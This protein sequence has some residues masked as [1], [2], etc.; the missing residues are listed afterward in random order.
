[1][2]AQVL[3]SESSEAISHQSYAEQATGTG[4][5]ALPWIK[6]TTGFVLITLI[7]YALSFL[8]NDKLDWA[9]LQYVNPDRPV[10]FVDGLMILV[11]DYSMAF[12]GLVLLTLQITCQVLGHNLFSKEG[13]R[14]ALGITGG[15]F[16][17][18]I[19]SGYIWA[20]Y[21]HRLIFIPLALSLLG[22]Y[23]FLGQKIGHYDNKKIR[24]VSRL[25]GITLLSVLLTELAVGKI[26]KP[27]VLRPRPLSD[28]Y[29]AC[30]MALRIIADE[31]VRGGHSYVASH[32]AIFFAM[33]TPLIW[34]TPNRGFKAVLLFWGLF[35]AFTR[36]YLAAHFP[37]DSLMG[38]IL[39]FSMGTVVVKSFN[40]LNGHKSPFRNGL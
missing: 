1:M 30:N 6:L 35:H 36:V 20:G 16:S 4:T 5:Q 7:F 26:I 39:G 28:A 23:L 10:P 29:A 9:V 37:Y 17:L 34:F 24:Q 25:F 19:C 11:T 12:F 8:I 13:I 3:L 40:V 27:L 32:S 14:K 22:A 38:G 31:V 18:I 21:R 15:V 2:K 33:I